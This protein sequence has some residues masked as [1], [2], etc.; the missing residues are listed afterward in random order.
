M[1]LTSLCVIGGCLYRG[2][3]LWNGL[4]FKKLSYLYFAFIQLI[5]IPKMQINYKIELP[6]LYVTIVYPI[7]TSHRYPALPTTP[8]S[9]RSNSRA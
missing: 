9:S 5:F 7:K 8:S 1:I 2:F 6:R 3:T 4:V